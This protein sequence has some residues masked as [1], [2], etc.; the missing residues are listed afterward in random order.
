MTNTQTPP[1][2]IRQDDATIYARNDEREASQRARDDAEAEHN[3]VAH[4]IA[5]AALRGRAVNDEDRTTYAATAEALTSARA[6][7][8]QARVAWFHA[9]GEHTHSNPRLCCQP[10]GDK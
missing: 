7:H 8:Q 4:S 9:M 2:P 6:A 3:L 1:E 10:D 5:R